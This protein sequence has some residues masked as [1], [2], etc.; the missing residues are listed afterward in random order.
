MVK[1]T[2]RL[3]AIGIACLVV[4]VLSSALLYRKYR[5]HEVAQARA[6]RQQNGVESLDAARIGGI[7]QWVE[8]RGQDVSNP[9]LLFIHGGP[10]AVHCSRCER[11][12]CDSHVEDEEWHSC[13][14]PPGE[15]G[16]ES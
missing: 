5:Q 8:I 4:V 1:K 6:I 13:A 2:L 3:L 15:E 9:I 16:G 11:W 12:F 14:L 10:G 7:D